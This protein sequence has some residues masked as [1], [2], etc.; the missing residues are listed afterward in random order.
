M[1]IVLWTNN[2]CS[3]S[4]TAE[5]VL[6][7]HQIPYTTRDYQL[8]PPTRQELEDLLRKTGSDDPRTIARA[9]VEGDVLAK[10]VNDPSLI[11]RPIA[12]KGDRAVVARP[13]EKVLT[14]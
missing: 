9:G 2:A 6:N 5:Q 3:K 4:R 11:E 14:L 7:E 12:I 1:E 10:L 8:D 13:P